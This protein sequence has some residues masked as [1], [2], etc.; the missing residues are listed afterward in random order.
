M[1]INPKSHRSVFSMIKLILAA[2]A[3]VVTAQA[4][5]HHSVTGQFDVSQLLELEGTVQRVRWVNPHIYIQLEVTE[6]NG[7][8]TLWSLGTVPVAMAR[9]AGLNADRLMSNGEPVSVTVFP[10]RD[11]TAN[12]GWMNSI[13]FSDGTSVS[14]VPDRR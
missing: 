6:E 8:A 12:L 4:T 5:G 11:G 3:L 1:S 10:A 13:E 9:R 2:I 14:I 7:E